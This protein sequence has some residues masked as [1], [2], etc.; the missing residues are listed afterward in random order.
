MGR[1][2]DE[3][4]TMRGNKVDRRSVW[5]FLH[6]HGLSYKKPRPQRGRTGRTSKGGVSS[7]ATGKMQRR[8][9]QARMLDASASGG[10]GKR[11]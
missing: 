3:L 8:L 9:V 11:R 4:Q 7:G 5:E 10:R 1:L 6:A 2:V